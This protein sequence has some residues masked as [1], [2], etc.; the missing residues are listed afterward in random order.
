MKPTCEIV[1]Y[2]SMRLMLVCAIATTLP[3]MIDST[4]TIVIMSCQ[5][6]HERRPG[7]RQAAGTPT[8]TSRASVRPPGTASPESGRRG[9]HRHPRMERHC[10]ELEGDADD[11]EGQTEQQADLP[12]GIC[13]AALLMTPSSSEP[14]TP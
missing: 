12:A 10:S 6:S 5:P 7:L 14:V 3:T 11:D 4:A 1:E 2:A 13:S 8:Q 9:R